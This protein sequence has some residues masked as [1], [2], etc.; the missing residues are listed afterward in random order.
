MNVRE[1]DK[2]I[3]LQHPPNFLEASD[4]ESYVA[5]H[6]YLHGDGMSEGSETPPDSQSMLDLPLV[7]ISEIQQ[8]PPPPP[9]AFDKFDEAFGASSPLQNGQDEK[10]ARLSFIFHFGVFVGNG[11]FMW[12]C[13]E[14]YRRFTLIISLFRDQ[15]IESLRMDLEDAKAANE[16][17]KSEVRYR[18][19]FSV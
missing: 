19:I 8:A 7:D 5:P 6:A 4:F 1:W 3:F 15:M 9:P 16:R 12:N 18:P 11:I 13:G 10:Y 14:A 2:C 17:L